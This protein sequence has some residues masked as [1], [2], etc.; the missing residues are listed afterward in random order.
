MNQSDTSAII[1]GEFILLYVSINPG[2]S[3]QAE[4]VTLA[5]GLILLTLL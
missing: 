1:N 5:P 3:S 4:L 2:I